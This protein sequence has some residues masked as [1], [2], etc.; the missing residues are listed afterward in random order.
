VLLQVHQSQEAV[1]VEVD[2]L[3]LVVQVLVAQ[4]AVVAQTMVL[5]TQVV[6]AVELTF[7]FQ[8]QLQLTQVEKA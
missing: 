2:L 6:A 3:E 4:V 5:L 7:L 8:Q 1:A